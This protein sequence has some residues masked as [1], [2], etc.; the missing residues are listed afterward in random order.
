MDAHFREY[1]AA[2]A[3]MQDIY[4]FNDHAGVEVADPAAS[5]DGEQVV[6]DEATNFATAS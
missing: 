2:V 1:L 3:G 6:A 5:R 4:G